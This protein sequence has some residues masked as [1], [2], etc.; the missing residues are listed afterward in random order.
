[1]S[2]GVPSGRDAPELDAEAAA[3]I[4]RARRLFGVA[5]LILMAG[6]MAVGV[7]VVYRAGRDDTQTTAFDS[8][9]LP[10][11]AEVISAVAADGRLTLTYRLDGHTA[12]RIVSM[13]DGALVGEV[14][15]VSE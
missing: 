6:L 10:A 5:I 12:I 8:V 4:R 3:V 13:R 1:M 14:Q 9:A 7:G 11:G 15:V 2:Q